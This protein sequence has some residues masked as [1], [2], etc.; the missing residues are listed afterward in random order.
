MARNGQQMVIINYRNADDIDV[1]FD[2]GYIKKH[3]SF[4]NFKKGLIGH[5]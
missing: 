3:C 2:D 5:E 1:E 4:G